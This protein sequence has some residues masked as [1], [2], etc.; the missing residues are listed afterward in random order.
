MQKSRVS[1]LKGA[2]KEAYEKGFT[3][4]LQL[5]ECFGNQAYYEI[6]YNC[7]MCPLSVYCEDEESNRVH[8]IFLGCS[9]VRC[10]RDS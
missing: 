5:P 2:I 3:D 8:N 6:F 4:D 7:D 9:L 1:R 10:N